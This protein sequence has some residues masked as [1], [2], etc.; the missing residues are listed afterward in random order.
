MSEF[1]PHTPDDILKTRTLSDAELLNG[2]AEYVDGVMKVTAEQLDEIKQEYI[3]PLGRVGLE[4]MGLVLNINEHDDGFGLETESSIENLVRLEGRVKSIIEPYEHTLSPYFPDKI[5]FLKKE[6]TATHHSSRI[7]GDREV[8][9]KL[10]FTSVEYDNGRETRIIP[11]RLKVSMDQFDAKAWFSSEDYVGWKSYE[12]DSASFGFN[13]YSE[14]KS[15][16]LDTVLE[17]GRSQEVRPGPYDKGVALDLIGMVD[18]NMVPAS[19]RSEIDGKINGEYRVV[20]TLD[21]NDYRLKLMRFSYDKKENSTYPRASS[22]EEAVYKFIPE[23]N[24]F[25]KLEHTR[26][27]DMAPEEVDTDTFTSIVESAVGNIPAEEI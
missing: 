5:R 8:R 21:E 26:D 6:A 3:Q 13:K 18:R 7:V 4:A 25:I 17:P 10:A 11:S 23:K 27:W 22:V 19:R 14:I 12:R 24:K 9:S 2:G 1:T 20:I 15:L 16:S